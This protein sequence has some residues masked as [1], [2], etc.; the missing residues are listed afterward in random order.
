MS[1]F[2]QMGENLD[3]KMLESEAVLTETASR[4]HGGLAKGQFPKGEGHMR[5]CWALKKDMLKGRVL[6]IF[7]FSN[8]MTV[9]VEFTKHSLV[10]NCLS[11]P[12]QTV[13]PDGHGP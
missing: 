9:F 11:S 8:P 3:S 10:G 13:W 2:L 12:F 6:L 1:T 5:N 4:T 7:L